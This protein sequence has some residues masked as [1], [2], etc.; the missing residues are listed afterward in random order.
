[1]EKR[2]DDEGRTKQ[3]PRDP[4]EIEAEV[5]SLRKDISQLLGELETRLARALV[6]PRRMAHMERE[7]VRTARTHP[8]V[9]VAGVAAFAVAIYF[10]GRRPHRD[11]NPARRLARGTLKKAPTLGFRKSSSLVL[12]ALLHNRFVDDR[13]VPWRKGL[14]PFYLR[15]PPIWR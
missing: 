15:R 2:M 13:I 4:A 11:R 8:V 5:T 1:M 10:I 14:S 6:V 7:V 3:L 12:R 9:L